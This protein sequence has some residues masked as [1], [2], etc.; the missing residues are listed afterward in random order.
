MTTSPIQTRRLNQL[1]LLKWC[2]LGIAFTDIFLLLF[3]NVT[4]GLIQ[5]TNTSGT[6]PP[7]LTLEQFNEIKGTFDA[8]YWPVNVLGFLH[9]PLTVL[10]FI[11]FHQK[12]W[13]PLILAYA[14]LSIFILPLGT[15]LAM[16]LFIFLYHSNGKDLFQK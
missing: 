11:K 16:V 7:N 15:F 14:G 13:H 1:N 8:M 9:L 3:F 5:K 4:I 6:L 12:K 10:T 2:L